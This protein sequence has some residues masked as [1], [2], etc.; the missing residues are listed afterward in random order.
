MK[1]RGEKFEKV[2]KLMRDKGGRIDV[3]DPDLVALLGA[4]HYRLATYMYYIRKVALVN[5][6]PIR[7]VSAGVGHKRKA[8]AYEIVKEEPPVPMDDVPIK[9]VVDFYNLL[10]PGD[11]DVEER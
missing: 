10:M 1:H 3:N 8:I 11:T 7:G 2:L 5:V 6:R 4:V 9:A